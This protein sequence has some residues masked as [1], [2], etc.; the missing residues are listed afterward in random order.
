MHALEAQIRALCAQSLD[1]CVGS[2]RFDFIT[3]LGA[4]MPM[5]VIGM[6]LGIPEKDFDAVRKSV[7]DRLRTEVGKPMKFKMENF[8]G[9]AFSEFEE[10]ITWR[11]R[12]P[13]DDIMTELLTA[14]F[15]DTQGV[16][17][18]LTRD[19]LVAIVNMVAGA[20]N[21]TTNRLIGWAGKTLGEHP[22]QRRQLCEKPSLIPNAIEELLRFEPPAPAAARLVTRDLVLHGKTVPAGSVMMFLI[23]AAN[24]DE[25]RFSN[26]DAFDIH[27]EFRPHLSFGHGVH[28][29]IG[30]ALARL[31]GRVALEEI[32]K[33]FPDWEVDLE[34][35]ELS[36]TSA[37]RGWDALPVLVGK[38]ANRPVAAAAKAVADLTDVPL[39]GTWN[40]SVKGPTGPQPT[41]LV[42]S[43]NGDVYTG[44]QSGQG[45]TSV[46][47][48]FRR[49]GN[50]VSWINHV[51]TPLKM[52]VEFNGE[53]NGFSMSGKVKA[54]FMGKYPF[55]GVKA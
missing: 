25:T 17:R 37:V 48:D 10:Y 39:E 22:D 40:L 46:I 34:N 4:D 51:T 2:D 54:G 13:S 38:R 52:K 47:T 21:E 16:T 23:G 12:H 5:R 55:S 29:C 43:R 27:R 31:E 14:E 11:E 24:R 18:K 1:P 20:G 42:L 8:S 32:L 9:A 33:R 44:T 50:K 7:D 26:G 49:E 36:S 19:E 35:A 41:V 45:A 15:K 28:V 30:A 6:L 53:V 3:H